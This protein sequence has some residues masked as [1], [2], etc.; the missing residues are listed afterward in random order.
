M[1]IKDDTL[2]KFSYTLKK[3][4]LYPLEI[5]DIVLK[6]KSII[7]PLNL[8]LSKLCNNS[9]KIVNKISLFCIVFNY[10]WHCGT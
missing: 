2:I 4:V 1:Y 10:I 7:V 9:E 6:L 3:L 8:A 5:I